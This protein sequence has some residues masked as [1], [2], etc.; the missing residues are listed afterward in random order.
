[1]LSAEQYFG[2]QLRFHHGAFPF[3]RFFV[4][5]QFEIID[6][7]FFPAPVQDHGS[8]S[9]LQLYPETGTGRSIQVTDHLTDEFD[10]GQILA[11]PGLLKIQGIAGLFHADLKGFQRFIA[12]EKK[13]C[14]DHE[15]CPYFGWRHNMLVFVFI[16]IKD[17]SFP[18]SHSAC[19]SP[20]PVERHLLPLARNYS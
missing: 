2:F 12:L 3:L 5:D 1:M 4:D 14:L 6:A 13:L 8:V 9:R 15:F 16:K 17:R 10:I 18:A 20:A 19:W 11:G 7:I